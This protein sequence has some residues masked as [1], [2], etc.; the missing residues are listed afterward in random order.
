MADDIWAHPEIKFEEYY[1]SKLQ[2]DYLE[3]AGFKI[4]WD[5]GQMSTA[6]VAEWGVGDPI[7]GFIGEFDALPGLSQGIESA[8]HPIEENGH[9]HGCGH[10][11][12]GTGCLAARE[13][14]EDNVRIHY[15]ITNGG[16][17]PNIV[18]DKA[19]VYYY[20][21]AFLPDQVKAVTERVRKVAAGA[22][23]MTE[24]TLEEIYDSGSTCMLNNFVL[25]DVQAGVMDQ[26]GSINFS[27]E[28]VAFAAEINRH[29][30]PGN[31]KAL[32]TLF[33][34]PPEISQK[35][36]IGDHLPNIDE[37]RFSL[38]HLTWAM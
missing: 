21:R 26:L 12:L 33:K 24:T 20:V 16:L 27:D 17:A 6:F 5:L 34:L 25:A 14:V 10:N 32:E 28:E 31:Q 2:A 11:L 13:H 35:P 29:N 37:G 7:L 3:E 18:P 30:P 15:V 38:R 8:L 1:A 23:M 19:E 4:T 22:A 36:L 9:G